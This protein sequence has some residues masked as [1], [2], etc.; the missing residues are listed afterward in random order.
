M[1]KLIATGQFDMQGEYVPYAK[2][3]E[4]LRFGDT[5]RTSFGHCIAVLDDY[6]NWVSP[7]MLQLGLK[8]IIKIEE[9]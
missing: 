7:T 1:T 5:L 9:R 3:V 4:V 2:G 6:G 8:S